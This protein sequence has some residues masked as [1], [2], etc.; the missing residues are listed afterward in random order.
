MDTQDYCGMFYS[1]EAEEKFL[2]RF[3]TLVIRLAL[4]ILGFASRFAGLRILHRTAALLT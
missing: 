2:K 3:E 4:K 1:K